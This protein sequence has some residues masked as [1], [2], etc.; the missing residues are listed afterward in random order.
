MPNLRGGKAYKKSKGKSK[1]DDDLENVVFIDKQADQ[2]IGRLV[3]LLG[4]RNTSIYC[5][6]N[7]LRICKITT[8]VKKK[9]RFEVGD[10]VLLSLRDC[11]MSKTDLAKGIRSDHGDILAKYSPHQFA[12]LKKDGVNPH[13]FAHIDTVNAMAVKVGDGDFKA[14]EALAEAD[15]DN[16]F[17]GEGSESESEKEEETRVGQDRWKAQRTEASRQAAL[18]QA[19]AGDDDLDIDAI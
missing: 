8:G 17:E 15:V 4:N 10:I 16:I 2:M 5:E 7:K 14:A 18:S 3:R 13:L 6:D 11:D 9:A 1:G 12:Q 19:K